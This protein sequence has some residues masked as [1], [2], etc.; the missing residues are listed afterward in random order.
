MKGRPKKL[1]TFRLDP[2]LVADVSNHPSAYT[3]TFAVEEGLRL[4][5]KSVGPE[6]RVPSCDY[7]LRD[8]PNNGTLA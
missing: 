5:L 3:L 6:N 2:G 7:S 1:H 8:D 4:W